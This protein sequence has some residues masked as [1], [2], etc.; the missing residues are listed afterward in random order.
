MKL[1]KLFSMKN[2]EGVTP[3]EV[4]KLIRDLITNRT[5]CDVGCGEGTFMEALKPF[6]LK[7][8]GIEEEE[9]WAMTAAQKGFDVYQ[10]NTFF[11]P[12]PPADVYY[13]W[14]KDAMGIFLKARE[15]GTRGTF[16]F[17]KTVRPSL[18]QF[19]ASIPH[20]RRDLKE[21]DWW[22]YVTTL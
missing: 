9:Q 11:N 18:T 20:E 10:S 3:P 21:L 19:L 5:V 4:A 8:I 14:S 16:I 2:L 22:V 15:E 1:L 13:L 17:G 12:L 6:A 7:V